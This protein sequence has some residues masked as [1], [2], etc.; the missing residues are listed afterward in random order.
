MDATFP[1]RVYRTFRAPR[2]SSKA[3]VSGPKF[4]TCILPEGW[5]NPGHGS[6][7]W[8]TF[9]GPRKSPL[10]RPEI[11]RRRPRKCP[12]KRRSS[13]RDPYPD[14]A[15]GQPRPAGRR[16]RARPRREGSSVSR[17]RRY[18]DP[19]GRPIWRKRHPRFR[20]SARP[21]HASPNPG[22][23]RLFSA[24]SPGPEDARPATYSRQDLSVLDPKTSHHVGRGR[25]LSGGGDDRLPVRQALDQRV[26]PRRV[27]LREHIV[28]Q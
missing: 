26:G 3:Q 15:A 13:P 11:L 20:P 4:D 8:R 1:T 27:E 16:R 7:F 24:R 5:V 28:Q 19:P 23:H 2:E 9:R 10:R 14:S 22:V 6:P 12:Q 25:D 17:E 21:I 18:Q